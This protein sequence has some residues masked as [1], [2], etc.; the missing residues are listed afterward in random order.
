MH[1]SLTPT[2]STGGSKM[3]TFVISVEE[4]LAPEVAQT[5]V[6]SFEETIG[7]A[8]FSLDDSH[9]ENE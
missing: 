5:L 7:Q 3:T 8:G 6:E 1:G 9:W 4:D 2:K